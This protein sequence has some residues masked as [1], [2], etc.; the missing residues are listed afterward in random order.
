M[1]KRVQKVLIIGAIIGVTIILGIF[2]FGIINQRSVSE[3]WGT[4]EKTRQYTD[5]DTG[6]LV[7]KTDKSIWDLVNLLLV[8]LIIAV[9]GYLFNQAQQARNLEFTESQ[10]DNQRRIG[11]DRDQEQALQNYLDKMGELLLEKKLSTTKDKVV[12]NLARS[13]TLTILRSL[14]NQ[15]LDIEGRGRNRRKGSLA[16]FLYEMN[17]ITGTEP[18]ISLRK[19]NLEFAYMHK[20]EFSQANFEDAYLKEADLRNANL[21]GSILINAY[22]PGARLN[23]ANLSSANLTNANLQKANLLGAKL[24]DANLT[25]ADLK[26]T[27]MPD[28]TVHA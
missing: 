21:E 26:E 28:G 16:R 13:R 5:A 4:V 27:I 19:A 2:L 8:P 20:G 22:L 14:N 10:N 7:I 24:D 9:G 11:L 1:S 15:Y 17:L 6:E 3:V 23:G 25:G 12:L 18:I